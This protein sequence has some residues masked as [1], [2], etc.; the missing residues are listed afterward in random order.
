MNYNILEWCYH[1]FF[2]LFSSDI[3][4]LSGEI[5]TQFPS[6]YYPSHF[7]RLFVYISLSFYI[8]SDIRSSC[9]FLKKALFLLST[10]VSFSVIYVLNKIEEMPW[11]LDRKLRT[12]YKFFWKQIIPHRMTVTVHQRLRIDELLSL[13]KALECKYLRFSSAN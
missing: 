5:K 11:I 4:A 6:L 12:F 7:I 1:F 10:Q 8:F 2:S 3:C 13:F 9:Y